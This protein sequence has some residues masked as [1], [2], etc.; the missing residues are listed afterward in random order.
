MLAP[1]PYAAA[2]AQSLAPDLCSRYRWAFATDFRRGHT[3]GADHDD[4]LAGFS[5]AG[6]LPLAFA[7]PGTEGKLLEESRGAGRSPLRYLSTAGGGRYYVAEGSLYAAGAIGYYFCGVFR[8]PSGAPTSGAARTM[9]SFSSSSSG[10]GLT[11]IVRLGATFNS[12]GISGLD[13]NMAGAFFSL[14]AYT[15]GVLFMDEPDPSEWHLMELLLRP[16]SQVV[17]A[18]DGIASFL[19]DL[20]LSGGASM[21]FARPD[22]FVLHNPTPALSFSLQ[23]W[24]GD[25]AFFGG[26]AW[27]DGQGPGEGAKWALRSWY[28]SLMRAVPALDLALPLYLPEAEP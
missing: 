3:G 12:A 13:V 9:F 24:Q 16:D 7:A 6:F 21:Y 19:P 1:V 10:E 4:E 11:N 8:W 25:C 22:R 14:P 15:Q 5:G 2:A 27:A 17:V 26:V 23:Q 28:P 20:P 18:C